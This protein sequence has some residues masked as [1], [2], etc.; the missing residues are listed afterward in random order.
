MNT[1]AFAILVLVTVS[2]TNAQ[3]STV[4]TVAPTKTTTPDPVITIQTVVT[5]LDKACTLKDATKGCTTEKTALTATYD[6]KNITE[7]CLAF[8]PY[9]SCLKDNCKI[10]VDLTTQRLAAIVVCN[11]SGFLGFSTMLIVIAALI[12]RFQ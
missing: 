12:T 9:D 10:T 4:T 11:G 7:I 3:D 6:S 8:K 1:L 5:E 2:A